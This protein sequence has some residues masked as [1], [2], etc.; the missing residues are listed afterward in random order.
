[1][2]DLEQEFK[3][4]KTRIEEIEL[5]L[6]HLG[7]ITAGR[8]SMKMNLI[9]YDAIISDFARLLNKFARRINVGEEDSKE[10]IH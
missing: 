4:L 8:N 10:Q 7:T 1:M 5:C 2:T 3:E 6:L 9:A